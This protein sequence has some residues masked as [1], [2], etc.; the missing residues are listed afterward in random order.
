MC[1]YVVY[2]VCVCCV[3]MYMCFVCCVWYLCGMYVLG[4]WY[5]WYECIVCG[6][7]YMCMY[8]CVCVVFVVFGVCDM[9]VWCVCGVYECVCVLRWFNVW[10]SLAFN[11]W[12]SCLSI[13]IAEIK[14]L[15]SPHLSVWLCLLWGPLRCRPW[16]IYP[17]VCSFFYCVKGKLSFGHGICSL[18]HFV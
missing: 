5:V 13:W 18:S 11:W 15:S 10:P 1:V 12:S 7:W 17:C 6:M 16:I 9:G 8:V 14:A 4:V 3:Y 2:G